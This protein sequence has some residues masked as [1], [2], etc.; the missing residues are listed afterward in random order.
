MYFS[1]PKNSQYIRWTSLNPTKI[2][3]QMKNAGYSFPFELLEDYMK[4]AGVTNGYQTK[5]CLDPYD[6][7]CPDTA[8]NKHSK[9]VRIIKIINYIYK[10]V[11][12]YVNEKLK[13]KK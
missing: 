8:P 2:L 10:K 13:I 7:A 4:R 5:P 3:Q 11:N 9:S 1:G 12:K 6:P